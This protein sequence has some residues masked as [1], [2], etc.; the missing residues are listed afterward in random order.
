MLGWDGRDVRGREI[1]IILIK[2]TEKKIIV[3]LPNTHTHTHLFLWCSWDASD[4]YNWN[5]MPMLWHIKNYHKQIP[6]DPLYMFS[7]CWFLAHNKFHKLC[8]NN[9][10]KMSFPSHDGHDKNNFASVDYRNAFKSLV[11]PFKSNN[12]H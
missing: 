9:C 5:I 11:V 2:S 6:F 1:K 8:E 10:D 4:A 12:S 7:L 3:C